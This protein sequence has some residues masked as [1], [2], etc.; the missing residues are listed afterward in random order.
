MSESFVDTSMIKKGVREMRSAQPGA[1]EQRE[2]LTLER[3]IGLNLKLSVSKLSSLKTGGSLVKK[4]TSKKAT[5]KKDLNIKNKV[6]AAKLRQVKYRSGL[7][8]AENRII[9]D[10][11]Q[12]D[13]QIKKI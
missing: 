13:N 1:R 7:S 8:D 5:K 3:Q 2:Q 10:K 6:K 4:L 11:R 12:A 9:L